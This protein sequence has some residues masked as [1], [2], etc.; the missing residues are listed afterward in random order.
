MI[1]FHFKVREILVGFLLTVSC[2]FES[3][4][5]HGYLFIIKNIFVTSDECTRAVSHVLYYTVNIRHLC[6][7]PLHLT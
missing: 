6:V 1:T 3:S 2:I 7:T 4:T 5:F